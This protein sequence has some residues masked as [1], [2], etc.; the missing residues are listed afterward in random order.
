[1]TD[2]IRIIS[3]IYFRYDR[4]RVAEEEKL[5]VIENQDTYSKLQKSHLLFR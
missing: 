3:N 5:Y 2:Q 4:G 1:M